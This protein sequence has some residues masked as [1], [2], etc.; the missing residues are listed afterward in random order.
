M[1]NDLYLKKTYL[2][3]YG[4][5]ITIAL[6]EKIKRKPSSLLGQNP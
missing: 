6:S 5:I 1:N 2:K 4:D 3:S